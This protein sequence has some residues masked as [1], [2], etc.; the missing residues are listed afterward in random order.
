MSEYCV[1]WKHPT[2][3]QLQEEELW[4]EQNAL[5]NNQ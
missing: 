3:D 1:G 4:Q 2:S 5:Y